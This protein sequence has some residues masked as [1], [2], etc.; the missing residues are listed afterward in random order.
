MHHWD[1]LKAKFLDAGRINHSLAYRAH[2]AN[3]NRAESFFACLRRMVTGQHRFVTA[4]YLQQYAA[5]AAWKEDHRSLPNGKAS[6]PT[7]GLTM[8]S[9][10]RRA[11]K[12]YWQRHEA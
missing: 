5:D 4:R 1:E 11:W 12:G 6:T 10:V 3:T 8:A 2:G 9:P 7:I